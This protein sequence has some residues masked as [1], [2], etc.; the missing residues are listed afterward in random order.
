MAVFKMSEDEKKKISD[1]HKTAVKQDNDKKT[2]LK[3]G[4][5]QPDKKEVKKPS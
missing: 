1:Q 3:L 5:K 2:E 4:L